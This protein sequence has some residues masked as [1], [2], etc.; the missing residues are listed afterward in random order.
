MSIKDTIRNNMNQA[1]KTNDP[2][3]R[4][5]YSM[6]LDVITKA[7][8]KDLKEYAD[9]EIID[10]LRK[11]IKQ[12]KETLGYAIKAENKSLVD[13]TEFA[14]RTLEH[15]LPQMMTEAEIEN[16][17]NS[18]LE[19]IEPIKNNRGQIMKAMSVLKGKADMKLVSEIVNRVLV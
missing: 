7:E 17:L 4:K 2:L 13:E 6:A 11:E 19:D 10:V 12:Y 5:I 18:V 1:R 9:N 16:Y 8:K 15:F 14:I 3:L